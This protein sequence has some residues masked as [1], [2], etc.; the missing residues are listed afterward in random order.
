MAKKQDQQQAS[1]QLKSTQSH[2][3]FS[4]IKDN[5]IIMKDGSM[6]S[7][8]LA[9]PVNFDLMSP[10]ERDSVEYAYQGFLNGLHFPVQIIIRSRHVDLDG[11]LEKLDQI[12]SQHY[13]LLLAELMG[14]Y[15]YNI[16]LLLEQVNIMRKEFYVVVP[17]YID[18]V[19]KAKDNIVTKI[20]SIFNPNQQ[21]R[22]TSQEYQEHRRDLVQ[23]TNMVSQNLAQMGIRTATLNTREIIELFYSSYNPDEARSQELT[24]PEELTGDY[25][26][27]GSKLS[28]PAD[29]PLIKEPDDLFEAA[30]PKNG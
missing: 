5:L 16:R 28:R 22:Q 27:R 3:P 8:I 30:R 21:V 25:V 4:E 6:R 1:Q 18:G 12:K 15:I 29:A 24:A 11:Y 14:E 17:Y 26:N 23:R 13:N 10:Q 19:A 9:S 2:L 7:I 20:S